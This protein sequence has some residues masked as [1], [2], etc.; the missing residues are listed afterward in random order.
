MARG[1]D[2]LIKPHGGALVD[3]MVKDK[4]EA[5]D[6]VKACG[7]RTIELSDRGACDV[8]LLT[9]GRVPHMLPHAVSAC[10]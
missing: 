6:L 8:E 1:T 10:V 7:G 9:V 2:G 5:A 4:K 3:L